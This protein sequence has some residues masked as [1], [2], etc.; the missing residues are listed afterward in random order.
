MR[1]A[2]IAIMRLFLLSMLEVVLNPRT[3]PEEKSKVGSRVRNRSRTG[4]TLSRTGAVKAGQG[5][6]TCNP[7][8]GFRQGYG[9][10]KSHPLEKI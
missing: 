8:A 2:P 5:L 1:Y 6:R 3:S 7:R 9:F 10:F 4:T